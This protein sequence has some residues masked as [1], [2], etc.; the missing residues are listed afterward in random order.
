MTGSYTWFHLTNDKDGEIMVGIDLR[1][2]VRT[3]VTGVNHSF[4]STTIR[5]PGN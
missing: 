1:D 3:G 4:H 2:V 5:I